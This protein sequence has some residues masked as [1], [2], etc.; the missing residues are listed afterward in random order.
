RNKK[1][2]PSLFQEA[3]ITPFTLDQVHT[4]IKQYV[5]VRQPLWRVSD[6]VEA[7]EHIPSLKE[8][9]KNPFLMALSLEVLPR[10]VDPGQNLSTTRVTRVTLYDHFV[11]QWLERGKKRLGEKDLPPQS[12]SAFERL[13]AEGFTLNGIGYL[14]RLAIAIYK[15]QDGHPV[16]EYSQLNDEGTWKAAFFNQKHKQL[17]LEASPL[18]RNGNQH[19]F[20]HRSILE[21]GLAR[22][23]FDP[24]DTKNRAVSTPISGR[25]TRVGS[26]SGYDSE[27]NS[28]EEP[29]VQEQE[30]DINSPLAWR[31][32]VD[33]HSLLQ[34]LEERVQQELVFKEQLLAYIEYSKKDKKWS[35]AAANAITIL[36]R[37]GA[38]LRKVNLRG[39]WLR[40]TDLSGA[41]MAGVQ[42]GEQPFLQSFDNVGSCAYSPDGTL[43]AVGLRYGYITVYTTS[44]WEYIMLLRGHSLDVRRIEYSPQGDQMASGSCD[45]TVRL[46][47]VETG[48]CLHVL[49]NH[50]DEVNCV[51][52]SPQGDQVASASDDKTIRIWDSATGECLRILIGHSDMV[53]S[54]AYAPN[55]KQ[56]ASGSEDLTVRL[57]NIEADDGSRILSG[58]SE[59]VW[60]IAY[61]PDG[62][63]VASASYDKTV[64]TWDVETGI[65]RRIFSGHSSKVSNVVYSPNGGQIASSG[66]DGT[67][68]L[69]DVETGSCLQTWTGHRSTVTSVV[70]SPKGDQIASGSHDS[71][72]RLW[73]VSAGASRIASSGHS[74]SVYDVKYSAK[75]NLVVS[76]SGD[77]TIRLWDVKTGTCR[78]ILGGSGDWVSSVAFSPQGDQIA[79]GSSGSIIQLWEVET[80][81]CQHTMTGQSGDSVSVAYSPQGDMLAS[82]DGG[83]VKLWDTASGN[84]CET[85]E[86]HTELV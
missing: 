19:R 24:Q 86:G 47:D 60:D 54:V 50:T 4:Y 81:K 68:Q 20:I 66:L 43:F 10:I 67:V 82:A 9:V 22:A 79:S 7:L 6:Y 3:V 40:E 48:T 28:D 5:S 70:Y 85:L 45:M 14:K 38:D 8:L 13:S 36:V 39:V 75:L 59:K 31:S 74:S 69:W 51:A 63:Q 1:S 62:R 61:S 55:G 44:N 21:Y 32:F 52:Y 58:H 78:R 2:D 25:R 57:W 16:V 29:S 80:G 30:P 72:V 27:D 84:C 56:I 34:F 73:D 49:T 41:Q 53:T 42:L 37:A 65:T 64:R 18:T 17:L 15:E 12:K 71:T 83:T 46:W 23:I 76:G 33:E 26:N 77:N 11:E 35:K